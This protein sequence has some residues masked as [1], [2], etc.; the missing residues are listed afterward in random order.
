[1]THLVAL[2]SRASKGR[3]PEGSGGPF[4]ATVRERAAGGVAQVPCFW[5][6]WPPSGLGVSRS[7]GLGSVSESD[8]CLG[9]AGLPGGAGALPGA[10]AFALSLA[11]V[12]G[13]C[14]GG[15]PE[16]GVWLPVRGSVQVPHP[17]CWGDASAGSRASSC[18]SA[19][20]CVCERRPSEPVWTLPGI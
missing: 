10:L 2:P 15:L 6:R 17:H 20:T 1:M 7:R 13:E 9:S 19:C 18:C 4:T 12:I 11:Q 3:F 14:P 16:A 5:T 8:D